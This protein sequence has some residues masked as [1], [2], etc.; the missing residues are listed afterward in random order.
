M[1]TPAT[2][3]EQERKVLACWHDSA[4]HWQ[5]LMAQSCLAS[6]VITNPAIEQA[7]LSHR[8]TTVLDVGCGEGWLARQLAAQGIQVTAI[9]AVPSLVEHARR[10]DPHSEYLC[11]EYDALP[12]TLAEQ[13][14]D[15]AVCNFSLFGDASVVTLLDNLVALLSTHG[16]LLIQTLH[17]LTASQGDYREGWRDSQWQGLDEQGRQLGEAPPW[18][19]RSLSAWLEL[20]QQVGSLVKL[21]EPLDP[22]NHQPLSVIFHVQLSVNR[23]QDS[24]KP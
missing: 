10:Q 11:L 12:G 7:I 17:P 19:F 1:T 21:E 6:R 8:P 5:R 9:D 22:H 2:Q 18:Y 3:Q 15:L 20:L 13:H 24:N 23:L 14:F 16:H 4:E